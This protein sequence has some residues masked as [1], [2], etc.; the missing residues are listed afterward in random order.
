MSS[1]LQFPLLLFR[2]T[3]RKKIFQ[4]VKAWSLAFCLPSSR[5][6]CHMF[7][8][9]CG[10]QGTVLCASY[11][12]SFSEWM[13]MVHRTIAEN[14]RGYFCTRNGRGDQGTSTGKLLDWEGSAL[15]SQRKPGQTHAIAD[16][17][18]CKDLPDQIIPLP[19]VS[20]AAAGGCFPTDLLC[21]LQ[22][23]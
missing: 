10:C 20:P 21:Q 15:T 18:S 22:F 5:R 4:Y 19:F 3:S 6:N 13:I 1:S 16:C 2:M 9:D 23:S 17:L 8:I 12:R 7:I 11:C 14:A